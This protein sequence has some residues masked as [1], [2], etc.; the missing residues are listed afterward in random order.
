MYF[1]M[2]TVLLHRKE[3]AKIEDGLSRVP[4]SS[5]IDR[6]SSQTVCQGILYRS[7]LAL[8][9]KNEVE[10]ISFCVLFANSMATR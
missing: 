5:L 6:K 7:L 2:Q 4:K 8:A 1:C 9:Y 3:G 10:K